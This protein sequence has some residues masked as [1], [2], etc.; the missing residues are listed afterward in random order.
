MRLLTRST[1]LTKKLIV[2]KKKRKE[3]EKKP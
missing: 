1:Q 3:R 2:A